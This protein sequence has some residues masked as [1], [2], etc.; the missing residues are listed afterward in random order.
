MKT[1]KKGSRGE[2][3]KLLQSVLNLAQDG[4]FGAI[5]E[6]AVKAFQRSCGLEDD[7]IV[8]KLTWAKLPIGIGN[9]V[10]PPVKLPNLKKSKRN[11]NEIIVH[12]T[13]T[14]EGQEVSVEQVRKWHLERGFADIGYHY[15]VDLNGVIHLGRDVDIVGAHCT[16]HNTRSIG[17]V[18]VGGLDKSGKARDTRTAYQ[19]DGLQILLIRLKQLYPYA[20]IHGHNEYANKACP[21]FNAYEE[22]KKI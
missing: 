10:T 20:T 14:K 3:V 1:L 22:Y 4:I 8:G 2:D 19:K 16:N 18:Y 17:V 7:G 13:A 15:L 6:E 9:G 11:I 5:T 21:C 12:C